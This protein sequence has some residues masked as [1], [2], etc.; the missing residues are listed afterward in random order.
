MSPKKIGK[1]KITSLKNINS[2]I[3]KNFNLEKIK[4]NKANVLEGTKNKIGNF[5]TNLKKERE[6]AK[7][8]LEKEKKNNKKKE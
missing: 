1:K 5:Y 4:L 2:M 7:K 8:R 3:S 6:K